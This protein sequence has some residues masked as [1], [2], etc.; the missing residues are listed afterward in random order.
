MRFRNLRIAWSVMWGALALLLCALWVRSYSVWDGIGGPFPAIK[1]FVIN[2]C[3]GTAHTY[4]Y[5][6]RPQ[7][8][9]SEWY[10]SKIDPMDNR[11]QGEWASAINNSK[12]GFSYRS[13]PGASVSISSPLWFPILVIAAIATAPWLRRSWRFSLR[14]LLIATTLIALILGVIAYAAK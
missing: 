6:P 2:S 9:I 10:W 1:S 8:P 11:N 5:F 13:Y 12:T 4:L 7:P 14:T 3:R